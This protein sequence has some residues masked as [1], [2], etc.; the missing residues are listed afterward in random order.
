ML[1]TML[2]KLGGKTPPILLQTMLNFWP[3]Y[4]GA[5]IKIEAMSSDY[6]YL[7][8][9]LKRAFYNSNYVG[10]QYGGSIYS[11]TDPFYMFLYMNNLGP[12]YV[13]WDKGAHIDF[14]KPGKT[15]LTAEFRLTDEDIRVAKEMTAGGDK[16]VF[17]KHVSVVDA[18]GQ[19]VAKV[20]K[21]LY[22]R[23]KKLA[24]DSEEQ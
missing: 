4:L 3:P 22:I 5:G 9:C 12:D 24:R 19:V 14:L 7:R 20:V 1:T 8:V 23:K 15:K 10:V 11:F 13:V 2:R 16:Y 6:R 18:K 21:T 17:D